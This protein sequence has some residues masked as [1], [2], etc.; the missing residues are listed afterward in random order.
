[1]LA[2]GHHRDTLGRSAG[3]RRHEHLPA[4]PSRHDPRCLVH[5]EA[6]VLGRRRHGL[7]SVQPHAHP[8]RQPLRPVRMN[9]RLLRLCSSRDGLVDARERNEEGVPLGI[10]L[11]A[12]VPLEGLP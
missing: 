7:A 1:M 4:V 11:V 12:R 9:E 5:V 6:D 10:D 2:Q 3:G 8:D